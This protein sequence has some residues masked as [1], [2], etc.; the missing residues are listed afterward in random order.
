ML[1]HPKCEMPVNGEMSTG[2]FVRFHGHVFFFICVCLCTVFVHIVN[3]T[4]EEGSFFFF[5][6][7]LP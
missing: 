3:E 5:F 1:S 2:S 6:H 4:V 7:F